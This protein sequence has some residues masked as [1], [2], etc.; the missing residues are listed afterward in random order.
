MQFSLARET[1]LAVVSKVAPIAGRSSTLPILTQMLVRA[2]G[3]TLTLT[4][5]DLDVEVVMS[6]PAEIQAGGELALPASKLKDILK[7][8]PDGVRI[9]LATT[10]D[11]VTLSA[12][13]SRFVLSSM[14]ATDYP[15]MEEFKPRQTLRVLPSQLADLL[16]RTAFAA[17]H[18]DARYYL[19][20]VLMDVRTDGLRCV[21]TNGHR[22]ALHEVPMEGLAGTA[23][24]LIPRKGVQELGRL[25]Q[26]CDEPV[27]LEF[28]AGF[29]RIRHGRVQFTTKLIDGRFPDY[30]A[31][32]PNQITDRAIVD[33]GELRGAVA[34][35]AILANEQHRGV[36]LQFEQGTLSISAA[37]RQDEDAH[38]Q[39]AVE[40]TCERLAIGF[41]VDYLMEALSA[42]R[43]EQ[44]LF[45][46][47]RS[48]QSA[49]VREVESE[50][51]RQV[52][53]PVRM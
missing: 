41:N 3:Q 34:R 21:A 35:V 12:G 44:V 30:E 6:C 16:D 1:L 19:N 17:A 50:A 38:E 31:V 37:N 32:M 14:A 45:L 46:L 24:A 20:G 2:E 18:N 28:G 43:G 5:T 29:V 53:M 23:Q 15:S 9:K 13:R 25:L 7:S 36:R 47:G 4:A 49:L 22:L 39:V 40:T 48:D 33:K 51:C 42:I 26:G 8:L 52:I 10:G 11:R 27:D